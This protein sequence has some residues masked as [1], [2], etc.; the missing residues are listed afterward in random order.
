MVG[1]RRTQNTSQVPGD[2]DD[3]MS[4]PTLPLHLPSLPKTS[5][6]D[7]N[8]TPILGRCFQFL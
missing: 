5:L 4:E 7:L 2:V 6:P 1:V 8:Q 3:T